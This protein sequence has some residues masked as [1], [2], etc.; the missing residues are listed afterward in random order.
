MITQYQFE[1]LSYLIDNKDLSELDIEVILDRISNPELDHD[2]PFLIDWLRERP[3]KPKKLHLLD[4][5][6][7]SIIINPGRPRVPPRTP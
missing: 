7:E 6:F 2:L 5:S 1:R 4:P 3:E